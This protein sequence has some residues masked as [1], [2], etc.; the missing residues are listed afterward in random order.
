MQLHTKVDRAIVENGKAVGFYAKG[1]KDDR[2]YEIRGKIL[3][4][5]AG[6]VGT[7]SIMQHSGV[8]N[9]GIQMF[10]DPSFSSWALLP[11]DCKDFGTN[12]EHGTSVGFV[13]DEH[14]CLFESDLAWGRGFWAMYQIMNR[15]IKPAVQAYRLHKRKVSIFNKIHDEG[16]GRITWDRKVSKTLTP[17]DEQHMNYCRYV[18]E[19]ILYKMGCEPG[20]AHHA[21]MSHHQGGVT[22]GHPGGSCPV[23]LVIDNTLESP[24]P[25]LFACD[26]SVI[27]GAPSRPPTLTL[28][29]LAK[30]FVPR[31]LARLNNTSVEI[32]NK[33]VLGDTIK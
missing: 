24:I 18:N 6:G 19:E 32:E 10:G 11:E 33:H 8:T 23:G 26:I 2:L 31:V 20:S 12:Y 9:A 21:G 27:P 28:V 29:T 14:G 1:E 4:C 30:W 7:A 13:D 16:V 25:N 22:F 15:G 5:S 17:L 3:I